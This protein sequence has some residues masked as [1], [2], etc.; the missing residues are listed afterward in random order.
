MIPLERKEYIYNFGLIPY[1]TLYFENNNIHLVPEHYRRMKR[2]FKILNL[3]FLIT[4]EKF[5][6]H[7][8]EY[9]A[10]IKKPFGALRIYFKEDKPIIKEKE[11][12]YNKEIYNKGLSIKISKVKKHSNNILNYIKTFNMGINVIEEERAQ[13]MGFDTCLFLNEKEFITETA[14]GNIFFRREKN[15]YTPHIQNGLLPGTMR[16][17]VIETTKILGYKIHISFLKIEDIKHM[18][19]CFITTSIAGAFPVNN[20]ENINFPSR[21][22]SLKLTEFEI[23]KRPWNT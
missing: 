7:L 9:L 21:E 15:I 22:F 6:E 18:E 8:K 23:F 4:L 1:E 12:K 17:K 14:F 5:E 20:I 3:P 2:A 13:R 10:K 16:K 11:I 19:E